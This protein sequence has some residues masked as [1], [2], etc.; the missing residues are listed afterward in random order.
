VNCIR[1]RVEPENLVGEKFGQCP[2]RANPQNPGIGE[3]IKHL[4]ILG[5]AN[6]LE[7]HRQAGYEDR[8]IKRQPELTLPASPNSSTIPIA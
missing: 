2:E 5:Q 8:E 3:G 6:P 7:P 1:D 4:Q